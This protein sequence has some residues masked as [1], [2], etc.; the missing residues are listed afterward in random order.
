MRY[1]NIILCI[2]LVLSLWPVLSVGLHWLPLINCKFITEDCCIRINTVTLNLAYSYLA[3]YIIYFLTVRIPFFIKR[4]NIWPEIMHSTEYFLNQL[5]LE[6]YIFCINNQNITTASEDQMILQSIQDNQMRGFVTN[7]LDSTDR[8]KALKRAKDFHNNFI[9]EI[10]PYEDFL[11]AEQLI[12]FGQIKKLTFNQHIE[13]YKHFSK[14]PLCEKANYEK[15]SILI[16]TVEKFNL[17]IK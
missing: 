8:L 13:L 10:L 16:S 14:I 6:F 5:K 11:N 3:G 12:I 2:I 4:K 1:I 7:D 17:S 15:L 9:K